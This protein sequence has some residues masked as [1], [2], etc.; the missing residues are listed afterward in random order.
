M[1]VGKMVHD[2]RYLASN[3]YRRDVDDVQLGDFVRGLPGQLAEPVDESGQRLSGG[4]SRGS[5]KSP[6]DSPHPSWI[7]RPAMPESALT[8]FTSE[9]SM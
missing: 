6:H 1:I 9:P 7:L 4:Q 3:P 8:S 5:S 2:Y